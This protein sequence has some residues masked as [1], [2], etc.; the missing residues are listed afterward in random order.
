[1]LKIDGIKL[2]LGEGEELLRLRAAEALHIRSSEIEQL[3][4]VRKSVDAWVN[5]GHEPARACVQ[6]EMARPEILVEIV[7][8]AAV[9]E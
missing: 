4:I 2:R 9:K 3:R 6:A 1:M 8:A 7:V 5:N